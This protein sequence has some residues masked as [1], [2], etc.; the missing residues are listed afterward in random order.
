MADHGRPQRSAE[1]D[2]E[3]N[4]VAQALLAAGVKSQD[5]VAFLDK[6]GIEHFEVLGRHFIA[7]FDVDAARAFVDQVARR[8]PT[9][10]FLGGQQQR[11]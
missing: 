9:K 1:L 7:S 10:S 8:I 3:A 2:S 4:R 5:R 11:L 6:N